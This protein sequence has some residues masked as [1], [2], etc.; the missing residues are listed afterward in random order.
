[1][2][3]DLVYLDYNATTPVD[4]RVAAVI[5]KCMN[6][7]FGNPSSTHAYGES[8]HV[9][10]ERA[11]GQ[12]ASLIGASAAE[13][14]FTGSGSEADALAIRG[15]FL[16]AFI[17]GRPHSHMITQVTEHPAVLAACKELEDLHGVSS[18]IYPLTNSDELIPE[19]LKRQ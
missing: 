7:E 1:M 14:V 8:A 9:A 17:D 4:P 19:T 3:D 2:R 13:I 6:E 15:A 10:L 16:A 12:I 18:P 11:R 5:F